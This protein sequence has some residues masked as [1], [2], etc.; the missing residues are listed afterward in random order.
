[1]K[2]DPNF[3]KCIFC[4][5]NPADSWEHII[6]ECIGGRLQ[7]KMLCTDCNNKLG[8]KLVSKVKADPS[9]RLTVSNL[10]SEIPELF[11]AIEHGQEYVT[12]DKNNN[13]I[14]LKYKNSKL[15]I[16]AHKKEDGSIIEDTKKAVR[17][18]KKILQKE[19]LT[20]VEIADKI[21]LFQ[22]LEDDRVISLSEGLKVVKRSIKSPFPSLKGPLLDEKFVA[23]MAY[24]FLSLA[25][26][27]LITHRKLDFIRKF[28]KEG[29]KSQNLNI[30][31]LMT[32]CYEPHH[33][34]YPEFLETQVIININL[35]GWMLYEIHLHLGSPKIPSP[36][37][38]YLEDLKNKR[39]R[40]AKSLDE[41]KQGIFYTI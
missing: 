39:T 23:L 41:A 38:V 40:L 33:T 29:E 13:L 17:S 22:E 1:M 12:K 8:S 4:L 35:F 34:I 3:H 25:I 6:P 27:N 24:E 28:I 16:I 18:L 2:V 14:K 15:E 37:L 11:E 30:E 19:G 26:G 20:E 5:Q 31:H 10:K 32:R 9:I 21:Q 36:D 7:L